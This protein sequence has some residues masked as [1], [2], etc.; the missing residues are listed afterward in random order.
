MTWNA[1]CDEIE[2]E[3]ADYVEAAFPATIDCYARLYKRK[4][5]T[6]DWDKTQTLHHSLPNHP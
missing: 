4:N 1:L 3:I 5:A 6:L 2:Q